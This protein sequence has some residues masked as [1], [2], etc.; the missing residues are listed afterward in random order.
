MSELKRCTQCVLP[1]THETIHF[2]D[3][4]VCNICRQQEFKADKIDWEARKKDLDE[5]IAKYKGQGDYDC[6][7]PFSGG[8]DS[9][10]TLYYLVKEY[11]LKPLVV[12]FDHGFLRPN[13]HNNV[14]KT[15]RE[16]GVDVLSFT[17]NW[18]VV[19]KLML[20]T[21]FDKGD[22]CWHCHTGIFAYP[23][24]IAIEKKIPLIF[25][26]EPSAEYT[27]YY[28]YDQAEEVDEKRFNRFVNLGISA[29]DMYV[30]LNGAVDKRDL[31]PFTYPA[32]KD[33]RKLKYRSVCLGSYIPWDVKAN[34]K[35]IADE[36]GWQGD[37]VENVPPGYGYEKIE[38]YL[39]GVRDYIKYI[40]RGYTRPS[41][42]ATL[43]VRNNRIT[44]EEAMEIINKY[45][46]YKPPSLEL[47]LKHIGLTEEEFYEV[48][49]SHGVSPYKHD[50]ESDKPG[51]KT[52]DFE[53]WSPAGEMPREYAEEQ[54][55]L[56]R[57]RHTQD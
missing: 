13:L 45:E 40:K 24:Q 42:L 49:L 29:E 5:L 15:A 46:G 27:A 35:L 34:S 6:L 8:K 20:Q 44:R 33:L 50:P 4:G 57:A 19:Q 37:Q 26:G 3:E 43:D 39:Q 38:C 30:R 52:S 9:T 31:N 22:F 56:W 14:M 11:G 54:M 25:W 32:L 12:R 23:M 1:E 55:K 17:P 2:D 16:L 7:V 18:R 41:H 47:F 10:Y 53:T 36:L 28:S 48:A 51:K 21:F